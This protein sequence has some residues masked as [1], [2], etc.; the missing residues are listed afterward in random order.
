MTDFKTKISWIHLPHLLMYK[1]SISF[2]F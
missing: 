2:A 1:K